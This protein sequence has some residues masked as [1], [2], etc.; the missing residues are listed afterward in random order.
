MIHDII[1]SGVVPVNRL[2]KVYRFDDGGLAQVT[3][4]V[5]LGQKYLPSIESGKKTISMGVD[6]DYAFILSEKDKM[7]DDLLQVYFGLIKSGIDIKDIGIMSAMNVRDLGTKDIN[8]TIQKIVSKDM[9]FVKYGDTEYRLGD[10]VVQIK[11]NYRAKHANGRK[12]VDIFNGNQGI[13][14]EV[15]PDEKRIVVKFDE[16]K[17][18]EYFQ[19]TM[20]DLS[21]AYATSV[22]KFQGS[23]CRVAIVL[24]PS[25]HTFMLNK[26]LLYTALTRSTE[27]TI[28]FSDKVQ[29]INTALKKSENFTR[30]TYLKELLQAK[31]I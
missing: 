4:K 14:T 28:H 27:R 20:K 5:R 15:Y 21:L 10:K 2:T 24:T 7:K 30:D 13:V 26:N 31:Q 22:H 8:N 9:P 3:T 23:G 17:E 11:N 16:E 12:E 25:S 19:D 18:I 6:K 29:T 1:E